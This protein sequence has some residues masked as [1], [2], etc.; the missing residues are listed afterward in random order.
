LD[1]DDSPHS[2]FVRPGQQLLE[3]EIAKH[4][5]GTTLHEVLI[6]YHEFWTKLQHPECSSLVQGM[7]TAIRKLDDTHE[8]DAQT[9]GQTTERLISYLTGTFESLKAHAAWKKSAVNDRVKH[10]LESFIYGQ[11]HSLSQS[12]LWTDE[13]KKAEEAWMERLEA[14]SFVTPQHLDIP[15]LTADDLDLNKVLAEPIEA[16][17]SVDLYYS[18][19]EKLQRILAM[20]RGVNSALTKAMNKN[21]KEGESEK[22]PSADDVLPTMILTVLK[23]KP[24]RI[25]ANL[26]LVEVSCPPEYLRG[27]AGYACTN[28]FGGVQFLLDLDMEDPKSLSINTEE[29]RKGL[30]ESRTKFKDRLDAQRKRAQ[31]QTPKIDTAIS[32]QYCDIPASEIR[33]ARLGGETVDLEW[34]MKWQKQKMAADAELAKAT[35]PG[36]QS[37]GQASGSAEE[38]LPPGFTRT[39]TFLTARPEDIRMSDLPQLL[40]EYRMLVHTSETLLGER[41]S[42]LAAERKTK[43]NKHQEALL[44]N[45][46]RVDPSLLPDNLSSS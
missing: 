7:R 17:L 20:Y 19:Y 3:S 24:A 18:P 37:S 22:L 44:A 9:L 38:V 23:A 35:T 29:F 8:E 46:R 10:S 12:K 45:I 2:N 30:E 11:C 25:N 27:E 4:P 39:Y 32:L 1:D 13:V 41:A 15:C 34:A 42:R 43:V 33:Q 5:D 6:G 14:L 26:R 28:L 40:S 16:L 36:G 31:L 21:R